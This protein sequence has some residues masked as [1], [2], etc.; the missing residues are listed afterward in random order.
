[1]DQASCFNVFTIPGSENSAVGIHASQPLHRFDIGLEW[2]SGEAGVRAC[3]AVGECAGQLEYRWLAIPEGVL[4]R[5][6]REPPPLPLV[7]SSPQRFVMQQMR[8]AFGD[9]QDGFCAFGAGRTFPACAGSRPRLLAAAVGNITEG[10]GRFRGR[11]GNVTLSG[12]L[13]PGRGFL[14]HIVVRVVDP[15]G[16]LSSS[17]P[18]PPLRQGPDPDPGTTYLMFGAQKGSGPDQENRFSTAPDGQVRGMNVPTQ[19]KLL[20]LDFAA[21]GPGGFRSQPACLGDVIG[22]EIGFGRGS[23]PDAPPT[24]TPLSPY[25]FEG[26]ARYSFHDRQGKTVG[27]ITTN[28]LEGRRFDLR[29]AAAPGQ[30]AWRF[31]F[32]G[33][34]VFGTGCFRGASGMFYG[35]SASVFNPPPGDHVITHL[36]MA[37]LDDPDGRWRA[38]GA[39]R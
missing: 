29:L 14:G 7:P 22:R 16:A 1:V 35:A 34:I 6:D 4:A 36:Y 37:R 13:T 31:G 32:F 23:V 19:A 26:V 39:K 9:G 3:N 2:P 24:G 15:E 27:A 25:L 33:P 28:V 11:E 38:A 5:P 17:A 21:D 18:L 12:E 30:M 10:F 8:F 20:R